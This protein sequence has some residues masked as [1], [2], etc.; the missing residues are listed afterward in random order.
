[1]CIGQLLEHSVVFLELC[2]LLASSFGELTID[3]MHYGSVDT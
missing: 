3:E 1:M 2:G